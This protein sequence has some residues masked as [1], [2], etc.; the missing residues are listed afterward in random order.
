[1]AALIFPPVT[2]IKAV[3]EGFGAICAQNLVCGK[4]PAHSLQNLAWTL[5]VLEA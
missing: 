3:G 5:L 1:V 4:N 2:F